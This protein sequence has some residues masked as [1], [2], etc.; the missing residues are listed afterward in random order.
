M[1][2][3]LRPEALNSENL[4]RF[5]RLKS[6]VRWATSLS[7]CRHCLALIKTL[8]KTL[9]NTFIAPF[10]QGFVRVL[11]A[12]LPGLTSRKLTKFYSEVENKGS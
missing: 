1:L 5:A 6:E 8:I 4:W 10:R 9:I 11:I 3:P 12:V 2:K 7:V